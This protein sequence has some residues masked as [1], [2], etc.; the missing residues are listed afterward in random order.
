[1]Q[2]TE[3]QERRYKNIYHNINIHIRDVNKFN[4]DTYREISEYVKNTYTTDFNADTINNILIDVK[5]GLS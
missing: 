2:V 3:V 4:E 1:M 5:H